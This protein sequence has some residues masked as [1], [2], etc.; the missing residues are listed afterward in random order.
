MRRRDLRT[1]RTSRPGALRVGALACAS[2]LLASARALALPCGA[3][4]VLAAI[5]V[6]GAAGVPLDAELSARYP[7][8]ALYIDEDVELIPDDGDPIFLRAVFDEGEGVLRARPPAALSPN[9]GYTVRWPGLRGTIS[10][11]RGAGAVVRFVTGASFDVEP[12]RFAGLAGVE[13][14]LLRSKN[15]CTDRIEERYFFDLTTPEATDDGGLG[16]LSLIVFQ[17]KGPRLTEGP[18]PLLVR[19]MPAGNS[20][21]RVELAVENGVGPVCFAGM[22]RDSTGKVSGAIDDVCVETVAPP[23]F[24]G[25]GVIPGGHRPPGGGATAFAVGLL[26]A[27]VVARRWNGRRRRGG[28]RRASRR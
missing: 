8:T 10:A 22:A 19:A 11:G 24:R 14:D 17:T 20:I 28:A 13:W 27:G 2:L 25:C 12:P 21:V 7:A 23:F 1:L 15:V 6:D 18:V 9:R 16:A 3:S 5:P 4:D 26:A